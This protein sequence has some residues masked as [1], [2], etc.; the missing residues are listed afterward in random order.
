MGK[1]LSLIKLNLMAVNF[2]SK[3]EI[4]RMRGQIQGMGKRLRG[5]SKGD[6]SLPESCRYLKHITWENVET[7]AADSI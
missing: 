1:G 2:S 7:R 6:L 5:D 4:D 3:S